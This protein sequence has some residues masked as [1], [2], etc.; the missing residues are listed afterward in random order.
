MKA[1]EINNNK[2]SEALRPNDIMNICHLPEGQKIIISE[3]TNEDLVGRSHSKV[4][5]KGTVLK[6]FTHHILVRIKGKAGTYTRSIDK[7]DIATGYYSIKP[8]Y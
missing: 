1:Y 3:T 6:E 5:F 7:V 4:S 8:I 2:M